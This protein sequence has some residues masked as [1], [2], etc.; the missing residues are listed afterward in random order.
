MDYYLL[1][2]VFILGWVFGDYV[3]YSRGYKAALQWAWDEI[4]RTFCK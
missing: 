4:E 3:G 1:L 2:A